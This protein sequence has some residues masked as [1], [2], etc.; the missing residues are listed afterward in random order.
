QRRFI[1]DDL[2]KRIDNDIAAADVCVFMKGTPSKPMCGFSRAVIQILAASGVTHVNAVNVLDEE[3]NPG[4]REGIKEYS[5]WP[6]IPQVYLGKHRHQFV[7]GADILYSMYQ[8]GEL[9]E[10]LQKEGILTPEE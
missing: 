7:G 1:S 4:V 2:R 9:K 8:S 6:T 3:A 5:D 10:L